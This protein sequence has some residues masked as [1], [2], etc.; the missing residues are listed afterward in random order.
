M[1]DIIY[2]KESF[3]SL[4]DALEELE[5]AI[6]YTAL[7][8]NEYIQNA[9][10][11]RFEFVIELYWKILQ[12]ILKYEKIKVITPRETISN[13]FKYELINDETLW[14]QMLDDRNETSHNYDQKIAQKV[15]T[16]IKT[17]TPILRESYTHLQ[18]KYASV[19]Q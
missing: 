14:L 18:N 10:I 1:V 17:Y 8:S 2:W 12:R 15:L 16:R 9:A 7:D 19:L 5:K 4:A 6:Y 3:L 13:A 11:Q